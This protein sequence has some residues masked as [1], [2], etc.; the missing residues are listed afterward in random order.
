MVIK[1]LPPINGAA[2]QTVN[3]GMGILDDTQG[4]GD[5]PTNLSDVLQLRCSALLGDGMTIPT[6]LVWNPVDPNKWYY[7]LAES[8]SSDS[9]FFVPCT[10]YWFP[11]GAMNIATQ[12]YFTFE[13]EGAT[14]T[15]S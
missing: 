4:S 6:E 5:T 2:L 10:I 14:S 7:T 12:I 15:T 13:F 11:N 9:R 1:T 8:S 3:L